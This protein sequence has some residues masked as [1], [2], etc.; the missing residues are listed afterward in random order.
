MTPQRP[1]TPPKTPREW[2][3]AYRRIQ[4]NIRRIEEREKGEPAK[5]N[6]ALRYVIGELL[7][8]ERHAAGLSQNELSRRAGINHNAAQAIE[9]AEGRLCGEVR[10]T[11]GARLADR[12][13]RLSIVN[14]TPT[15]KKQSRAKAPACQ[16]LAKLLGSK[17]KELPAPEAEPESVEGSD[18]AVS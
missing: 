4:Q 8:E 14:G 2:E 18:N 12:A 1:H 10:E 15:A 3:A 17:V 11:P 5:A 7:R 16:R 9:I 6:P 13:F